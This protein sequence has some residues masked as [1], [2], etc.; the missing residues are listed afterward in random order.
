MISIRRMLWA[1]M[2]ILLLGTAA[3]AQ[4]QGQCSGQNGQNSQQGYWNNGSWR[5]ANNGYGQNYY[6]GGQ[7]GQN[8]YT[9]NGSNVGQ[10]SGQCQRGNQQQGWN[11]NQQAWN[12]GS[13]SGYW[14]GGNGYLYGNGQQNGNGNN[15]RRRHGRKHNQTRN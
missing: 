6:N 5:R 3:Q 12:Q 4:T 15:G 7:N 9:N 14:Q 13:N 10:N 8:G 11:P 2:A 1:G